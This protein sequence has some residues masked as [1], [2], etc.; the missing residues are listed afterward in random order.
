MEEGFEVVNLHGCASGVIATPTIGKNGNWYIG[1]KDTGV[2]AK[3]ADGETGPVGAQGEK[4]DQGEIGPAGPQGIQGIQGEKGG[5]GDKGDQGI[6]GEKGEKGDKG[7]RGED[8]DTSELERLSIA[9]DTLNQSL[10]DIGRSAKLTI[11]SQYN[12]TLANAV[13][14]FKVANMDTSLYSV[15]DNGE[16]SILKSGWYT[17]DVGVHAY[18]L[19][20][21]HITL[22]IYGLD[23]IVPAINPL[24]N[25]GSPVQKFDTLSVTHYI[26]AGAL[27]Y[28]SSNGSSTSNYLISPTA[29]NY[30]YIKALRID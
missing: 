11:Q 4:G 12:F 24:N 28:I 16:V 19:N 2:C 18:M 13:T 8:A 10:N 14:P 15:T 29:T 25:F 6:Q 3:G 17:I 22:A 20:N 7:D 26:P 9:V 5:K 30:F 1:N 21:T 23:G 27:I